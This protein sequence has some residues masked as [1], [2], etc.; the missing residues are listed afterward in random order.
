MIIA[1]D[2]LDILAYRI[3]SP[4]RVP[5][6]PIL[7]GPSA[8]VPS[9]RIVSQWF[10]ATCLFMPYH[11]DFSAVFIIL[12]LLQIFSPRKIRTLPWRVFCPRGNPSASRR[13]Y[14]LHGVWYITS[15]TIFIKDL[16]FGSAQTVLFYFS[17]SARSLLILKFWPWEI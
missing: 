16:T 4:G 8:F 5:C 1:P 6:W 9:A 10:F 13:I 15:K 12:Y 17:N 11:D 7:I 2:K 14:Y 3:L